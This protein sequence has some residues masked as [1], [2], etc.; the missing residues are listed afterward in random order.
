M[1][2]EIFSLDLHEPNFQKGFIKSLEDR[3]IS[4][5]R[6]SC[7]KEKIIDKLLEER[8]TSSHTREPEPSR[9][10]KANESMLIARIAEL[11]SQVE[12]L[13]NENKSLVNVNQ[14]LQQDAQ[15]ISVP[16]W[17]PTQD[18]RQKSSHEFI[19][20]TRAKNFSPHKASRASQNK[21]PNATTTRLTRLNDANLNNR[22]SVLTV[23]ESNNDDSEER[24]ERQPIQ[25]NSNQNK[26]RISK[27]KENAK[28]DNRAKPSVT[29]L[30]DS[31]V[32]HVEVQRVQQSMQ[33]KQRVY[34]KYFNG[35]DIQDM[36]DFSKPII[37]RKPD[38]V[39]LH[40][41]TNEIGKKEKEAEQ[42]AREIY[43]LAEDI[44]AENI[45]VAISELTPRADSE[46]NQVKSAAVNVELGRLCARGRIP[47]IKHNNIDATK[48][49]NGSKLHLNKYGTS[50][51]ARN[52]VKF[53]RN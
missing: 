29:I 6:Q 52:Y 17:D 53:L 18:A 15:K 10:T 34:V 41:G 48:H 19:E 51:L 13:K 12:W 35:A 25:S 43:D 7:E 28:Q 23:E 8:F 38:K 11:Q 39:I 4:L 21:S 1:N 45:T 16:T 50:L 14:I 2:V 31:I 26:D 3:I 22:F 5:E 37:R 46:Q 32:K 27:Q 47:L 33:Y 20:I 40:I 42:I 36:T 30:G 44:E 9:A 49:L 24:D